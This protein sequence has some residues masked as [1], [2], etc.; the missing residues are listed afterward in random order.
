MKQRKLSTIEHVLDGNIVYFVRLEG[1]LRLDQLRSALFRVQRKHPALRA[2]IREAPDGLYY[3]ED[4]APEI[5]LRMVPRIAEDDYRREYQTE[6]TTDFA[7]DQPQLRAVWLQSELESDLL[8]TTSHRICDGMSMLTIVR[9]VLRSLYNDEELIPYAPIT[10][11]DMIGDYQPPQRWKRKL[12]AHL[13][14][15]LLR[16]VPSS[17][18]APENNEYFLEWKADRALSDALK[19]RCK[20][21]GISVHAALV[22]ALERALFGVYGKRLPKWIGNQIDPRRGRFAALKSDMLFFGGGSFKI[23]TGQAPEGEFWARARSINGEMPGLIEEEILRIP[24]RFHFME[25]L[26]PPSSG[27][28]QS[29]MRLGDAFKTSDRLTGFALSNLGNITINDSHAPFRVKDLRLYVHSFKTKALGLIAYTLNGEMRF[30]CVADEKCMSREQVG[31][32]KREFMAL[33]P[34]QVIQADDGV[35]ELPRLVG[36]VAE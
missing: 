32:L 16:L 18:R 4:S 34:R 21:E 1:S 3:E 12:T 20:A 29:I 10:L 17:R 24:G 36:A 11:Q 23:Q 26:R 13:V 6:L 28:I 7:Y 30:N 27:Q 9:E 19:R 2:L 22:A 35:S 14:N 31:A 5:P 15:S 8:F 25:Q 33:L